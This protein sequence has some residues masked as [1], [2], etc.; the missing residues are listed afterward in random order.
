MAHLLD[1]KSTNPIF[2]DSRFQTSYAKSSDSMT[3]EGTINK[4]ALSLLFLLV[5]AYYSWINPN[6]SYILAGGVLG[7]ILALVTVFKKEWSPVTV[8][9]YALSEGL[10]LGAISFF[11]ETRYPGIAGQAIFLTFAVLGLMLS[12]YRLEWIRATPKFQR[13]IIIATASITILYLV[14]LVMGFFGSE[15]SFIRGSSL[16]GI[17]FSFFVVGIAA[18]NLIL[19]FDFIEK[20]S[21]KNLPKYMEWFAAFGLLVTLVWLYIEL[22]RLLSKLRDRK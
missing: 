16:A 14:N 8:P 6:P 12:A 10:A 2:Q 5:S 11:F 13:M 18:L 19:D 1:Q 4:T 21:K 7:L 9:L 3:L 15:L 17:L 20:A 22:L